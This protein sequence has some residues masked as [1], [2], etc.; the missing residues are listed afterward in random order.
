MG[1]TEFLGERG[2]SALS[3]IPERDVCLFHEDDNESKSIPVSI[4]LDLEDLMVLLCQVWFDTEA[5]EAF[6]D[7]HDRHDRAAFENVSPIRGSNRV[8]KERSQP[9]PNSSTRVLALR[10]SK[11]SSP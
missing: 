6:D 4:T 5:P 2:T 11:E 3:I 10:K 1:K 9:T 7:G 8:T